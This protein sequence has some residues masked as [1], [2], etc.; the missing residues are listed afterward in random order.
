MT[1]YYLGNGR[2]DEQLA[3]MRRLE[4]EGICL[5]CPGQ[6]N[7]QVLHRTPQWTV[8]SND[9]PYRG[10][11]LHLL[12]VPDE[13]VTDLVDLSAEAQ[14]DFWSALAWVR[15]HHGLAHY[16]VAARNGRCEFTGGTIR[17]VHVHVVQGDVDDPRHEPVRV[18]LSSRPGPPR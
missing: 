6:L 17:H 12:L 14:R 18:K 10:T 7:R 11:R 2:T 8:T 9:F 13:H 1:L 15:D 16:G 5:F 3:E 4:A